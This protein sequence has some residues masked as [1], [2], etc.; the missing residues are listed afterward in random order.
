[1]AEPEREVNFC[2]RC[3]KRVGRQSGRCWF[4]AAPTIRVIRPA[5]RC[6]F[7]E[8]IIGH[9]AIKCP[10]CGEFVDGRLQPQPHHVTFVIDKAVISDG[11]MAGPGGP[12]ALPRAGQPPS[13]DR[14]L[15]GP[16]PPLL[17]QQGGPMLLPPAQA[18]S[19]APQRGGAAGQRPGS[20][21]RAQQGPGGG[22]ALAPY[23]G[24][25]EHPLTPYGGQGG[26]A[27]APYGGGALAP[28]V[29]APEAPPPALPHVEAEP[30]DDSKYANCSVCQ[31]E[32]LKT[33]NYCFHCGQLQPGAKSAWGR[34]PKLVSSNAPL[35]LTSL[36][37]LA[38]YGALGH[39]PLL[40][41]FNDPMYRGVAAT[42]ALLLPVWAFF[43]KRRL[44]SQA[45]S[46]VIFLLI[47]GVIVFV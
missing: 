44:F 21:D 2:Y 38:L 17:E 42:A 30:E 18:D 4:C 31:A 12:V 43:R 26:G 13:A 16:P 46:V 33:D 25:Q 34:P 22:S 20:V 27:L 28:Y 39:L 14:V 19:A 47:L 24:A 35:H 9:K 32:M 7:C 1:V 40:E 11:R 29:G 23:G 10:H 37:L 3:G 41:E 6:P 45:I 15:G 36:A 5:R 8:S